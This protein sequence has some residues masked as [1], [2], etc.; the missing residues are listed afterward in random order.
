MSALE[1]WPGRE[2]LIRI[3]EAGCDPVLAEEVSWNEQSEPD[4]LMVA[5]RG[6][7]RN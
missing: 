6:R 3:L 4:G 1:R 2:D 7:K 5:W